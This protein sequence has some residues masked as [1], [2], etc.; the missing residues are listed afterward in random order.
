MSQHLDAHM[1][2]KMCSKRA[3]ND[4][5]H[6]AQGHQFNCGHALAKTIQHVRPPP[7]MANNRPAHRQYAKI[8]ESLTR[9]AFPCPGTWISTKLGNGRVVQT[10][11]FEWNAFPTTRCYRC[12]LAPAGLIRPEPSV[13]PVVLC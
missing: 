12:Y 5:H 13:T 11:R 4:T 9:V 10:V 2:T 6:A 1:N 8:R 7:A 3:R